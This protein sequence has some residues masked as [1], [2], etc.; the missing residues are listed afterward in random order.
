MFD[1]KGEGIVRFEVS[2]HGEGISPDYL[3]YIWD[4]YYK[5]SERSKTHKRAKMGSGIGLSIVKSR[6]KNFLHGE[7]NSDQSYR[8]KLSAQLFKPAHHQAGSRRGQHFLVR[9]SRIRS[10]A[11]AGEIHEDM[12]KRG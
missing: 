11:G 8:G 5:V 3:P 7:C 2:D 9:S 12:E 4:R 6:R 1:R 10:A